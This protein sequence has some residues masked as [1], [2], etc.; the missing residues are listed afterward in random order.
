M[1]ANLVPREQFSQ[2]V[3]LS[4]SIG[5]FA[6]ISGPVLG[7]LLYVVGPWVPFACAS[8]FYLLAS[9]SYLM[10]RRHSQGSSKEPVRLAD[11]F[12]GLVFIWQ[13]PVILGAI[14]LD[15]FCV[16]LGGATALLPIIASDILHVGPF[17]LGVLRAM[18]GVGAMMLGL[19]LS[20]R[21]IRRRAGPKLFAATAIFGLATIGLGLSTSVYLS[22][23]LLWLIGASDVFSVVIRQT[24][25]QSDTPDAMRGR[26]AA[27][28][29]LFIGASN[30]LGEFESGVTAALFGLVPAILL[31]GAGTIMVSA[32]WAVMFPKP[33]AARHAGAGSTTLGSGDAFRSG[34]DAISSVG[35]IDAGAKTA[36]VDMIV[37][38]PLSQPRAAVEQ[39]Y[40]MTRSGT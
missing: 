26:V 8:V 13:R 28:N 3:G 37:D 23:A 39:R 21:P 5:Q 17:G 32:A 19:V 36:R 2:V 22:M 29:S 40:R 18:P 16:L 11:A 27:V 6:I 7:G 35:G 25:V 33:E 1:A 14:S 4:S 10:I 31:G 38:R 9:G 30:E 20:Y 15:L 34:Q 12:A 24:L